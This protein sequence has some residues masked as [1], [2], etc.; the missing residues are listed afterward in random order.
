M[1]LPDL[2]RKQWIAILGIIGLLFGLL[3]LPLILERLYGIDAIRTAFV[4]V[5]F[6]ALL[7]WYMK[8]NS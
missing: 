5:V 6:Y 4:V 8:R 7:N 1:E 2:D 3:A